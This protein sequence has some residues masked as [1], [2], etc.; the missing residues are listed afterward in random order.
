MVL[1]GDSFAASGHQMASYVNLGTEPSVVDN[2]HSGYISFKRREAPSFERSS[3][4]K[5]DSEVTIINKRGR[6]LHA[7][8]QPY[9]SLNIQLRDFNDVSYQSSA[10]RKERSSTKVSNL[11]SISNTQS[12]AAVSL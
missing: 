6:K 10:E 1:G 4:D 8:N 5:Y 11:P 9:D 12:K 2:A 7:R 3:I